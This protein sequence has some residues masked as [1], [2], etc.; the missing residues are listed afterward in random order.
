MEI[1]VSESLSVESEAHPSNAPSP[2]LFTVSGKV[3]ERSDE[4]KANASSP[5]SPSP[6]EKLT[7]LRF[8]QPEKAQ[9]E[10]RVRLF[11]KE[12]MTNIH[13]KDMASEP[14]G[15]ICP[16]GE[17]VID[18]A[19]AVRLCDELGIP[20]ALVEQDNATMLGDEYEQMQRSFN[21]LKGI[22]GI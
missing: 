21:N 11:G 13:F 10:T 9:D 16:C 2:I 6:K 12:R 8:L 17:G 7:F 4:Q 5:I 1:S 18:F 15:A 20:Y 14:A 19:P 3:T 22:F